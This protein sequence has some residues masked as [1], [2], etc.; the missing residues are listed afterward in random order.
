MGGFRRAYLSVLL[1][2]RVSVVTSALL[3]F[4]KDTLRLTPA[5]AAGIAFWLGLPWSISIGYMI[6]VVVADALSVEIARN[7]EEIGQIQTL[8]RMATLRTSGFAT[9]CTSGS[10]SRREAWR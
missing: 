8:G 1:T 2:Y 6:L 3:Y 10:A 7:D 5:E 9:A 4:E